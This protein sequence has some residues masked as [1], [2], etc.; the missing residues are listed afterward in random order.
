[1]IILRNGKVKL[2]YGLCYGCSCI[3]S[4]EPKEVKT[5][6]GEDYVSTCPTCGKAFVTVHREDTHE[7]IDLLKRAGLV[8]E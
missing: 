1:M 3:F 4:A 6:E 2:Y 5:E 7:S 8:A